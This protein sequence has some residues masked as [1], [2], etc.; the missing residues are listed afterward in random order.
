MPLGKDFEKQTKT[1]QD[2]KP[3]KSIKKYADSINDCPI[4]LKEKEIHNKLTDKSFEKRNSLD[5]KGDTNKLVFKYKDNTADSDF[6][7]FDKALSLINKIK[8]GE[9]S[10]HNATDDQARLRSNLGEIKRVQR[11]YLLKESK[12]ERDIIEMVYKPRKN[13]TDFVDE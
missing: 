13:A 9:V 7:E 12:K 4:I 10:L 5:K 2:K 6:S 8:D 11:K 3:I 1:I